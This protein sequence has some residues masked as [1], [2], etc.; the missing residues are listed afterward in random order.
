MVADV[1]ELDAE[2]VGVHL[3]QSGDQVTQLH[4]LATAGK[5][6]AV[7]LGVQVSV[8]QAME[9]RL[10]IRRRQLFSQ[11]ERIEVGSQMAAR[12]ISGE[13]AQHASLLAGMGVVHRAGD[14]GRVALL[15]GGLYT[16]NGRRVGNVPGLAAFEGFEIFAP[17]GGD[18]GWVCQPGFI[19]LFDIFGVA[20]GELRGF[21]ELADQISAHVT[22]GEEGRLSAVPTGGDGWL[23]KILL[24]IALCCC[25]AA[26]RGVHRKWG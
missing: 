18:R 3:L 23:G 1:H 20:A 25:D 21:E 9:R 10:Q 6:A 11:A 22:T 2:G 13:D 7:E 8:A 17:V 16:R 4:A 12:A 26:T 14:D 24:I 19:E 15:L 5:V